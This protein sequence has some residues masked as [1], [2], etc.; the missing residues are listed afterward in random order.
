MV[1]VMNAYDTDFDIENNF[2][3]VNEISNYYIHQPIEIEKDKLV[4]MYLVNM[5]EFDQINN[6]HL[7]AKM[8]NFYR[9]QN[10]FDH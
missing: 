6:S 1:K 7:H 3:T 10:Q 2:Y 5:L 8:F 9:L 4:R